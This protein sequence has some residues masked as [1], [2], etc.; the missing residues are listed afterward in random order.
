M[1]NLI[2]SER[3]LYGDSRDL[4]IMPPAG[5][6][7]KETRGDDASA[8]SFRPDAENYVG[9]WRR[10]NIPEA[11][12]FARWA[13]TE[14]GE[15]DFTMLTE[16]FRL[17]K[18]PDIKRARK[19]P[20]ILKTL[21]SILLSGNHKNFDHERK[22][23]VERMRK[24]LEDRLQYLSNQSNLK[25]F[26]EARVQ[27]YNSILLS[28]ASFVHG[29]IFRLSSINLKDEFGVVA[30]HSHCDYRRVYI[31]RY[32]PDYQDG[33]PYTDVDVL[34]TSNSLDPEDGRIRINGRTSCTP[35]FRSAGTCV[36]VHG[37]YTAHAFPV[38]NFSKRRLS[39]IYN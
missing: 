31:E 21:T 29:R 14:A 11:E 9:L 37:P 28:G 32:D 8:L 15:D 17:E 4:L 25:Y 39:Y 36:T 20:G 18:C 7:Y 12:E 38:W 34:S 5:Y 2:A 1:K 35:L 13:I 27:A 16:A 23:A 33:T 6:A 19:L 24:Y 26:I 3:I 10:D 30:Q 22:T